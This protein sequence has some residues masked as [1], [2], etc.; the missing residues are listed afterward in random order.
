MNRT[1]W[2]ERLPAMIERAF[3]RWNLKQGSLTLHE[4][5]TASWVSSVTWED[6]PVVL[7]IPFPHMEGADEARGLRYWNGNPTVR[8][9]D[10]GETGA[11]LLEH[12]L[13]GNTLR[14][15]PEEYQDEVLV[16]LLGRLWQRSSEQAELDGFRHL[17][18]MFAFWRGEVFAVEQPSFDVGLALEGFQV[19]DV[20]GKHAPTDVLLATDLHAGNVLQHGEDWRVIDPKPFVGE[21]TYDLVQHMLNCQ[22]RLMDDPLDFV[23]RLA[24]MAEV[25]AERLRLWLFARTATLTSTSADDPDWAAIARAV[26]PDRSAYK[27]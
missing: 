2:K 25:A 7:K 4:A 10:T 15:R 13:P 12:I 11:M 22:S 6:I 9:L 26:S 8:M 24:D 18:A 3:K 23:Q 1:E 5:P 14:Q 20:L 16:S 27:K 21:R 19:L 17:S